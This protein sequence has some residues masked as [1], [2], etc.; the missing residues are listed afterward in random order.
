M[1][2]AATTMTGSLR[3]GAMETTDS[4]LVQRCLAGDVGAYGELVDRY[5]TLVYRFVVRAVRNPVD[6]E[7]LTQDVFVQAYASLSRFRSDAA[8]RTWVFRIAHN[9]VIDHSRRQS[10]RRQVLAQCPIGPSD[11]E[12]SPTE[13]LPGPLV[14]D[15]LLGLCRDELS[16]KVQEAIRK[17]SEKLRVVVVLYDLE[18]YSYEEVAAI[19]G[20]PV[21]TVKSRLYNARTELRRRLSSYMNARLPGESSVDVERRPG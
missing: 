4:T 1:V 7:D 20:C 12:L 3:A 15:P 19:V 18:G 9:R 6:A 10:K 14:D 11:E 8:F 5:K 16:A 17:L 2:S 13:D 21:G